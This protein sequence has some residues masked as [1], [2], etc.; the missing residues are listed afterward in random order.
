M[1]NTNHTMGRNHAAVVAHSRNSAGS[2][3]DKRAPRGGARNQGRELVESYM[4]DMAEEARENRAKASDA[5][6]DAIMAEDAATFREEQAD[7]GIVA[8]WDE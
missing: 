2:M 6:W 3:K 7:H 1:S 8:V 4:D 5:A